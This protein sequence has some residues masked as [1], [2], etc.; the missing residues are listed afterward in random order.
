MVCFLGQKCHEAF[1][2]KNEL[3][4]TVLGGDPDVPKI[5]HHMPHRLSCFHAMCR[6]CINQLEGDEY[7]CQV[8]HKVLRVD[9]GEW[10]LHEMLL[11]HLEKEKGEFPID[12][13]TWSPDIF[14]VIMALENKL[15]PSSDDGINVLKKILMQED[16]RTLPALEKFGL[17]NKLATIA[18]LAGDERLIKHFIDCGA[19]PEQD[20]LNRALWHEH[21]NDR[22]FDRM[23]MLIGFGANP[24]YRAD[25]DFTMLHVYTDASYQLRYL[26]LF[27][28]ACGAAG[29]QERDGNDLT[30][31]MRYI[32]KDSTEILEWAFDHGADLDVRT[33][34]KTLLHL[35]CEQK[36]M[37]LAHA[38][39]LLSRGIDINAEDD[40]FDTALHFAADFIVDDADMINLLCESGA[41][42]NAKN[43]QSRTPLD[44]AKAKDHK[45]K[46]ERLI[47]AGAIESKGCCSVM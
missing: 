4:S 43:F 39:L 33:K 47:Q 32:E 41:N 25:M 35:V 12:F 6:R 42:V 26:E 7:E 40:N 30:P 22:D 8:C 45:N 46:V 3:D 34:G 27:F 5:Q 36:K 31:T 21:C 23:K 24:L 15:D 14:S 18:V 37:K 13:L 16:P 10:R 44:I 28:S 38:R 17:G 2:S 19:K 11:Y 1:S 9:R 29:F 20:A